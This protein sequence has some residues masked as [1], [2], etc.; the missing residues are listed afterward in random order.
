M[1]TIATGT[2]LINPSYV[3]KLVGLDT[4]MRIADLGCGNGY[5][6]LTAAQL[7]GPE[8]R[9]Y[10]VDILK[11]SLVTVAHEASHHSLSNVT[12]VWSNLEI[13]GATRIPE[14]SLDMVFIKNA[15]YQ[16]GNRVSFLKEAVRLLKNGGRVIVLEWL[17]RPTRIGPPEDDRIDK[18][19]VLALAKQ[20]PHL[21][22]VKEFDP[23]EYHYGFIF[24]KR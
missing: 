14:G 13:Y 11:T 10:A 17:K 21:H 4:A 5:F 2:T 19:E 22:F 7:V 8:G 16:S 18:S 24:Q 23:G 12:T 6:A 1:H 3:L 15:L 20:V 9:V